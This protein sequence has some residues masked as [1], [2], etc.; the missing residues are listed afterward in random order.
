MI[1]IGLGLW[2]NAM[3]RRYTIKHTLHRQHQ[4]ESQW[5]LLMEINASNTFFLLTFAHHILLG[6]NLSRAI[7][8]PTCP[9]K[10]PSSPT[11][12]PSQI[13]R[14]SHTNSPYSLLWWRCLGVCCCCFGF[15]GSHLVDGC[16]KIKYSDKVQIFTRKNNWRYSHSHSHSVHL[17]LKLTSLNV[18]CNRN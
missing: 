3:V 12:P 17:H 8:F 16:L 13:E 1:S 18:T 7:H 10:Y 11:A 15:R 9:M 2:T 14:S 5:R 4:S 6:R